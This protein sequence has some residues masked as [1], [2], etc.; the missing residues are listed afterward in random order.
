[1]SYFNPIPDKN[2]VLDVVLK[3]IIDIVAVIMFTVFIIIYLCDTA[4]MTGNS[5][6]PTLNN[7]ENVLINKFSYEL[8]E[9]E[10]FDVIVFKNDDGGES[11]KRII[12]LPGEEIKIED[13]KI[14]IR[15]EEGEKVLE[16]IYFE[17]KYEPGYV[18]EYME[19]PM[20]EYFVMGDSRNVSEDSRFEYVGN[21]RKEDIVGKVWMIY[22]PFNR[23][24]LV[25]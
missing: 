13:S 20:G 10:R 8:G 2:F 23:I 9:P 18:D 11:I 5:M 6:S 12:G 21:I 7:A 22:S 24:G 25:D 19:I 15:N 14:Y 17:G 3:W 1:M 4:D 16:D